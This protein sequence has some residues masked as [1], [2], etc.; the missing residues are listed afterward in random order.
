M[1]SDEAISWLLLSLWGSLGV[2]RANTVHL[3]SL[4]AACFPPM[5]PSS[6]VTTHLPFPKTYV[7]WSGGGSPH[8]LFKPL[9]WQAILGHC[10]AIQ[11]QE[12]GPDSPF[13]FVS[14]SKT[15]ECWTHW[16]SLTNQ[17]MCGS[18]TALITAVC[19][20][21]EDRTNQSDLPGNHCR[22]F[23]LN[24]FVIYKKFPAWSFVSEKKKSCN[25]SPSLLQKR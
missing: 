17:T 19:R 15:G 2:R 6:N 12:E 14:H 9:H 20:N 18:H 8:T 22:L 1:K 16:A 13:P 23:K 7:L 11:P 21:E 5:F 4:L 3:T 24:V 25:S 10:T